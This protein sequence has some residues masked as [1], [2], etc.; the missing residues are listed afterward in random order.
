MVITGGVPVEAGA[1]VHAVA[2]AQ[3]HIH[4]LLYQ[5]D[6]T[7]ADLHF[8]AHLRVALQKLG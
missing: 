6:S 2:H 8:N 7:V 4:A 1:V 3:G 5:I